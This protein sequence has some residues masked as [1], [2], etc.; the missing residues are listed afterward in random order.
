MASRK[1]AWASVLRLLDVCYAIAAARLRRVLSKPTAGRTLQLLCNNAVCSVVL[2]QGKLRP[3]GTTTALPASS[4]V[5]Q[6]PHW[7]SLG[8]VSL[9]RGAKFLPDTL[10][11]ARR[12][13]LALPPVE[14]SGC[15]F[16]KLE[17]ESVR[18]RS[19]SLGF[20]KH[21]LPTTLPCSYSILTLALWFKI[22]TQ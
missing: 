19:V 15:P 3:R 12:L 4:L 8:R 2:F 1:A 5:M 21:L 13:T 7:D 11:L 17:T 22:V 16:E 10:E 20:C 6:T 14:S 9:S 18:V